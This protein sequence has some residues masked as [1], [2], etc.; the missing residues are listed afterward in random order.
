MKIISNSDFDSYWKNETKQTEDNKTEKI[1]KKI[2]TEVRAK[3]DA[4]V[5]KF[6]SKFDKSS[7]ERLEV[8]L[9]EVKRAYDELRASDPALTD[10]LEFAANNIFRFSQKQKEQLS[11]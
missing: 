3:G 9:I 4:A 6:A 7:P 10:A 11:I 2:I 5:R 8:S 1:V